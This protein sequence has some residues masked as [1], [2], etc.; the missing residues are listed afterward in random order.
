MTRRLRTVGLEF[1]DTAPLR[2]VFTAEAFAPPEVVFAVLADVDGWPGWFHAVAAA[3]PLDEGRRRE[4]RLRGGTRLLETVL[5]ADPAERYAYRV[6]SA[7]APGLRALVEEWRLKPA[8]G[9]TRVR[10]TFALDGAP[11][12]RLAARLGRAGIGS[13]FRKA[14]RALDRRAVAELR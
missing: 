10:Y 8:G 7:T 4:V 12:V 13:A 2:L 6:D 11:P 5:A 3:R 9:G 1:L 14:V